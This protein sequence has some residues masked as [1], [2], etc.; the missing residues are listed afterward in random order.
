M[1]K[2]LN[3]LFL[4]VIIAIIS[5]GIFIYQ[6]RDN[7]ASFSNSS[8][9][10]KM[11]APSE[12]PEVYLGDCLSKGSQIEVPSRYTV[13]IFRR[14]TCMPDISL[15]KI[16]IVGLVFWPKGEY[17]S[18]YKVKKPIEG[19]LRKTEEFWESALDY[20]SIISSEY[21]PIEIKGNKYANEYSP[22]QIILEI[23]KE[24]NNKLKDSNLLNKIVAIFRQSRSEVTHKASSDEFLTLAVFIIGHI[25]KPEENPQRVFDFPPTASIGNALIPLEIETLIEWPKITIEHIVAHEIGHAFG[26]PDQYRF[27]PQSPPNEWYDPDSKNIMGSGAIW[28]TPLEKLHLSNMVKKWLINKL[29]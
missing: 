10:T 13:H 19:I 20:K 29:K 17:S 2:K 26:L 27:G 3:L 6:N 9:Q 24:L 18:S 15:E 11:P 25:P 14:Q 8:I 5:S 12:T 7:K 23:E 4:I 21:L 22:D 28:D 16:R 1:K